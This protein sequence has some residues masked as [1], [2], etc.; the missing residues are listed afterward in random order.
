MV[1]AR[2]RTSHLRRAV[3][4]QPKA[5][6]IACIDATR[7]VKLHDSGVTL[8]LPQKTFRPVLSGVAVLA[9]RLAVVLT[10]SRRVHSR[11]AA[12]AAQ[13][14][15]VP[16]ASESNDLLRSV[17]PLLAALAPVLKVRPASDFARG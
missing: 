4:S 12:G 14:G 8:S 2:T 11:S 17:H 5:D 15:S 13:A 1:Q 3:P 9:P 6:V 16:L 7:G 10:D